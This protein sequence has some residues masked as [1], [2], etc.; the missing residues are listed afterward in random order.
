V[1]TIGTVSDSHA[2]TTRLDIHEV[3][4]RLN[5]H[6]GA[7]LVAILAGVKDPKLPHKWA[8]VDGTVPRAESYRRLLAAHRVWSDISNAESDSTARSWF[9]GAN[10]RLG[11]V[12]P[13]LALREGRDED[14]L[15]AAKA[16]VE[17]TDD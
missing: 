4:R 17:G 16:F 1:S 10:P 7:T 3:A 6:L 12:S 5:S 9:I 2:E 13:I 15:A 14:V 11:E 8:K